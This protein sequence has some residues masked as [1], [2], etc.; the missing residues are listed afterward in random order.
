MGKG[1]R[2]DKEARQIYESAG[3]VTEKSTPMK[4]GRTDWFGGLFDFMATRTDSFR[5][6]QVKSKKAAGVSEM[7]AWARWHTPPVIRC[8]F[9]VYHDGGYWRLVQTTDHGHET[10]YDE[11]EDD[12]VGTNQHTPLNI[13]EGLAEFLSRTED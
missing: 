7:S 2:K 1:A 12:R 3:F 4:Y 9:L 8:E 10:V 11:R 5:L 6:V 13:G